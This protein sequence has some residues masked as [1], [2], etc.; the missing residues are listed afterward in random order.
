MGVKKQVSYMGFN[1]GGSVPVGQ[2]D[3]QVNI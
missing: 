2:T 3:I 1:I